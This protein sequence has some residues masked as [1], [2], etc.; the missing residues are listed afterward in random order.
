MRGLYPIIDVDSL[1]AR[2][3]SVLPFAERVLE[4]K[5]PLLQ[6]RAKSSGA[7]ETLALLRA[8][9]PL[10]TAANTLLFANDRADL[11]AMAACD[12]VH[13]GQEDLTLAEVRRV[14]PKLSVGV[15]THNLQQLSEALVERPD[16]VAFGPIF[17]TL[18]KARPDAVVGVELLAEAASLAAKANIPLV[19]IGGI[20]LER[21]RSITHLGILVAVIGALLPPDAD[22]DKVP[23]ITRAFMN[24]LGGV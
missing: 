12:G 3:L 15:S 21:A 10:C 7:A 1:R 11:A 19:A 13:V 22:L 4:A 18:S 8:L 23:G 2:G 9:R 5:P 24:A 17:P 14:A 16:Y 20:D 6:L